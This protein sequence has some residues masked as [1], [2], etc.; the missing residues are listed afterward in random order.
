[1]FQSVAVGLDGTR[2]GFAAVDWAAR[3]AQLRDVPLKLIQV[4][5][6][7]AY[8][9]SPIADDEV[10]RDWAQTLVSEALD[11]LNRRFPALHTDVEMVSGRPVH[12][13]TDA[14]AEAD[15][16]VMGSRGL[17]TVLGFIVGS[18]AMPTVTHAACPVVLVRAPHRSGEE[19]ADETFPASDPA[20]GDIVLGVDLSRP[21]DE[22]IGFAFET[23]ARH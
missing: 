22:L 9:Y 12:V 21:C 11:E 19:S 8:P 5:E 1:M 6:T 2:A 7:G 23:A 4:R 15:L 14:S 3:E 20:T 16:L 13:L 18:T 10:E 17:S